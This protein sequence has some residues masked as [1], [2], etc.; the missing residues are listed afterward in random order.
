MQGKLADDLIARIAPRCSRFVAD[1]DLNVEQA[2]AFERLIR[3]IVVETMT[4]T[5]KFSGEIVAEFLGRIDLGA[6][7]K[8]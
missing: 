5:A 7:R 8:H 3:E 2:Q 6:S 4:E 1:Y